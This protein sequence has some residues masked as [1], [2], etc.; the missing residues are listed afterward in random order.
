MKKNI[1]LSAAA[2]LLIGS[3]SL[4]ATS[5]KELKAI[6]QADVPIHHFWAFGEAPD[7]LT[8]QQLEYLKSVGLLKKHAMLTKEVK[9]IVHKPS[10]ASK[11]VTK[12]LVE[13][14]KAIA[15]LEK[16]DTK[17]AEMHLKKASELFEKAIKKEPSLK[18]IPVDV[19]ISLVAH[20]ITLDD[21]KK[22]KKTAIK[23]LEENRPQETIDLLSALKNQ[24]TVTT[25][26]IPM[27]LYPAA[28]KEA[29]EA[30]KKGKKPEVALQ[31]LAAALNAIVTVEVVVPIPV[32]VAQSAILE[33]SKLPKSKG[34]E[35]QKLLEIAQNRLDLAQYEGYLSKYDKEYK[36]LSEEI[37]MLKKK[38]GE[39]S[40]IEK[41][42]EKTKSYFDGLLKKLH[43]DKKEGK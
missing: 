10:E 1:L 43:E 6:E 30:L 26:S 31:T 7:H 16:K 42:Y 28:T 40:I 24:I 33:A 11:E 35:A 41:D 3:T 27:D 39:G 23:L 13:T 9:K 18:Q 14:L 22:I 34:K 20:T 8:K 4:Y 32:L 19:D 17:S 5:N 38:V 2:A 36:A 25:T 29:Y 15:T 37:K 21:A 12:G